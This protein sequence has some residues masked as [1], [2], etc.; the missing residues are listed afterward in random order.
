MKLQESPCY[1][2]QNFVSSFV[3]DLCRKIVPN[4]RGIFFEV[5]IWISIPSHDHSDSYFIRLTF[6]AVL[7]WSLWM[8]YIPATL[9]FLESLISRHKFEFKYASSSLW[10]ICS[11]NSGR[12]ELEKSDLPILKAFGIGASS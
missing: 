11:S 9:P 12:S 4:Q 10:I 5:E 2:R 1:L 3:G 7:N 6:S 8:N